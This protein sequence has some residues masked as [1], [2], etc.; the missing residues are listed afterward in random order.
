[1][2]GTITITIER[3]LIDR[4]RAAQT[5]RRSVFAGMD[6]DNAGDVAD[7]ADARHA[8]DAESDAAHWLALHV[9]NVTGP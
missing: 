4:F 9:S 6:A 3:A 8:M 1:M 2:P 7:R 5:K